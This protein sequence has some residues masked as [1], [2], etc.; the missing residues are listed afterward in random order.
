M[1]YPL[2]HQLNIGQFHEAK[3]PS[4]PSLTGINEELTSNYNMAVSESNEELKI[5][6][7]DS[8][9]KFSTDETSAN[10]SL[11]CNTCFKV[12]STIYYV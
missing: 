6:T 4:D 10:I 5:G 1:P 11:T 3:K 2:L 12:S 7:D 8:E 9:V